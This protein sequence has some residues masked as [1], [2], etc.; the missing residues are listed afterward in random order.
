MVQINGL[1]QQMA[2]RADQRFDSISTKLDDIETSIDELS[3]SIHSQ[4]SSPS[5]SIQPVIAP[6][7]QPN[8]AP[9]VQHPIAHVV[10][11]PIAPVVQPTVSPNQP[12][13][14]LMSNPF[15]Q[16]Y[17]D[18]MI[19]S[20]EE[21]ELVQKARRHFKKANNYPEFRRGALLDVAKQ[22]K[23]MVSITDEGLK[24]FKTDVDKYDFPFVD[25]G[26]EEAKSWLSFD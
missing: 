10:Q 16:F 6:A 18:Y 2:D 8:V 15:I 3:N 22:N 21:K 23:N 14:Q 17:N 4:S 19:L 5:P 25:D 11:Q 12:T 9:V 26:S 1:F 20:D 7:V 13:Q 24:L